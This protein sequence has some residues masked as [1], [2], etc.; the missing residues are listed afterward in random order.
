MGIYTPNEQDMI[1]YLCLNLNQTMLMKGPLAEDFIL[2]GRT[3]LGGLGTNS[4]SGRI[5]HQLQEVTGH[6]AWWD[7]LRNYGDLD[8]MGVLARLDNHHNWRQGEN[9][10]PSDQLL[11][12]LTPCPHFMFCEMMNT[13][14]QGLA[15]GTRLYVAALPLSGH[16][17]FSWKML[18][19][20]SHR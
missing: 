9:T 5:Y 1:S 11:Y 7:P 13:S 2:S 14:H 17:C 19:L 18:D 4:G 6:Q 16:W 20:K 8:F 12:I 15:M 10:R 3:D